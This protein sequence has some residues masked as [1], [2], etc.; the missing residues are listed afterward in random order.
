VPKITETSIKVG[1]LEW[2]YRELTPVG[3]NETQTVIFLHGVP[4]QSLSWTGL[5][6]PL[7]D[8]GFRSIAFDW[9]GFGSSSKPDKFDFPYT[10]N[11]FISALSDAIDHL[12]LDRFYLVVQGFLGTV[13]MQYA[14][15]NPDRVE[16]LA[17]LNAPLTTAAKLP[18]KLQQLG[19]PLVGDMLTQDPLSVDRTLEAGCKFVIPDEYLATYRRPFLKSSDAG[20]S[21]LAT[22]RNLKLAESLTEI[23]TGLPT[24]DI[25]IQIL[26][27]I[28]DPWL[29]VSQAETCLQS[30][31]N[32]TLVKIS[33]A[34]HY[35]QEHWYPQIAES[36]IPFLRS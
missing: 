7:A 4:S 24:L 15:R 5:M 31:K 19:L 36:L 34:A 27:G 17:I 20:R 23:A 14:I 8:R 2:F 10:P 28:N 33:E 30:L 12:E 21:L 13:G 6:T 9:I 16:K 11:A 35:P 25:P 32:G 29:D 26:W 22:M 3:W 1:S 18:W